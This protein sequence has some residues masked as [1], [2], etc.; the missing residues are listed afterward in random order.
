M[1]TCTTISA[2]QL[3]ALA[4]TFVL[5]VLSLDIFWARF[6]PQ[7]SKG[8]DIVDALRRR[9]W[10]SIFV[11]AGAAGAVMLLLHWVAACSNGAF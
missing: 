8:S 3:M 5:A 9:N 7:R 1:V 10:L 4:F 6:V 11:A 2:L